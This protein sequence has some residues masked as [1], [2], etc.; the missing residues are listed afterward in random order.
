MSLDW[1]WG[2]AGLPPC[3]V[4]EKLAS[5]T[6]V[7]LGLG[8]LILVEAFGVEEMSPGVNR[9]TTLIL[10]SKTKSFMRLAPGFQVVQKEKNPELNNPTRFKF[11]KLIQLRI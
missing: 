4:L 2:S 5:D 7:R 11:Q 1:F 3:Q 10:Y 8:R 9:V 6:Q